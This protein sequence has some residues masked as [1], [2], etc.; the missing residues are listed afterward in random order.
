MKGRF[1]KA[2]PERV[3]RG[4][5]WDRAWSLVEGCTRV[6]SGCDHCWAAAA[7][8]MR[9]QQANAKIKQRYKGLTDSAGNFTGEV[10]LQWE[11]LGQPLHLR[12]PTVFAVWNDLFHNSDDPGF[13]GAAFTTM[14]L[15]PEHTFLVCTKRASRMRHNIFNSPAWEL[16]F[17]NWPLPNVAL[18]VTVESDATRYRIEDLAQTPAALRYVSA[19]PLLGPLDLSPWLGAKDARIGLVIAGG[20]SGPGARPMHIKWAR[21]LRDQCKA[22]SVP[23]F[24]KQWGEWAWSDYYADTAERDAL[25]DHRSAEIISPAGFVWHPEFDGQP[26]PQSFVRARVGK[27]AAGRTLD[28]KLY[29]QW[30]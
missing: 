5:Y 20:E 9:S 10:R 14:N 17:R 26:Y 8:H 18:G 25:L 19:E 2:R 3:S 29:D 12:K 23:F 4:L 30:P 24:F 28:G 6:S 21:D 22:A 7:T 16:M 11:A 13:I 15:C 27:K 1:Q